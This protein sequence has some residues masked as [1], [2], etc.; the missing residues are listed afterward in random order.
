MI[1]FKPSSFFFAIFADHGMVLLHLE[2][3]SLILI[4]DSFIFDIF[5]KIGS[6]NFTKEFSSFGFCSLRNGGSCFFF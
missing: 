5:D 4:L 2:A 3:T 1:G 6:V